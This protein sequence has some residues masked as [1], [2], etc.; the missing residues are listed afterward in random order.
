ME[1]ESF[2]PLAPP[3]DCFDLLIPTTDGADQLVPIGLGRLVEGRLFD[4]FGGFTVVSWPWRVEGIGS[5]SRRFVVSRVAARSQNE[6]LAAALAISRL[7][8]RPACYALLPSGH[9]TSAV[10]DIRSYFD[11]PVSAA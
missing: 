9:G 10:I 11:A 4:R 1:V 5:P 7:L 6:A 3:V 2:R 8:L